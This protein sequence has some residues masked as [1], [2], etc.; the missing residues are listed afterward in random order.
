MHINYI[1]NLGNSRKSYTGSGSFELAGSAIVQSKYSYQAS[2]AFELVGSATT[3]FLISYQSTGGFELVGS[4]IVPAPK[5]SYAGSGSFELVGSAILNIKYYYASTGGFELF[6]SSPNPRPAK[7]IVGSGSFELIGTASTVIPVKTFQNVKFA[8]NQTGTTYENNKY[9]I[10]QVQGN[11]YNPLYLANNSINKKIFDNTQLFT[12]SEIIAVL[13]NKYN[14]EF[15]D[16]EK[17]IEFINEKLSHVPL[18][19]DDYQ[20]TNLKFL[21][22][23][24][25]TNLQNDQK[26]I[27][28]IFGDYNNPDYYYD[29]GDS[30]NF[31]SLTPPENAV[32]RSNVY[33]NL[34]TYYENKIS[35]IDDKISHT[36][37]PSDKT[38]LVNSRFFIND[39][40][41]NKIDQSVV[42]ISITGNEKIKYYDAED[43]IYKENELL[44]EAGKPFYFEN[45]YNNLITV[46]N[47]KINQIDEQINNLPLT[48]LVAKDNNN[49]VSVYEEKDNKNIESKTNKINKIIENASNFIKTIEN[50]LAN[51][52][53][54]LEDDMPVNIKFSINQDGFNDLKQAVTIKAVN[55]DLVNKYYDSKEN[56]YKE[57]EILDESEVPIY[58][59]NKYNKKI[60]EYIDKLEE[61]NRRLNA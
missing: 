17:T 34:I 47:N 4:A 27:I 41:F 58:F 25:F 13:A 22:N 10:L 15:Y 30:Y 40:A 61:I 60:D 32:Y 24:T 57:N 53:L 8:I 37:I 51:I 46:Y 43:G 21:I 36:P 11:N 52:D 45:E 16:Y 59:T 6:G 42:V 26:Q 1:L 54:K 39:K 23:E 44:D 14:K 12:D 31:N 33:N 56:E 48:S 3:K 28:S 29:L 2:G 5:Y 9:T 35:F 19:V 7:K 38:S 55:G 18:P 50:K 49:V 20:I